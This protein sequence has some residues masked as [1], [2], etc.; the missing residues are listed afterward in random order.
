VAA[1]GLGAV[2]EPEDLR[3]LDWS[4]RVGAVLSMYAA[5]A[6]MWPSEAVRAG[7]ERAAEA[8]GG[9]GEGAAMAAALAPAERV[10]LG[11]ALACVA[12]DS[13]AM[14]GHLLAR[15]EGAI[16]AYKLGLLPLAPKKLK[17]KIQATAPAPAPAVPGA[18][19]SAA[20]DI[21]TTLDVMVGPSQA[22]AG[23][24]AK[25]GS[26][27]VNV[28]AA[29]AAAGVTGTEAIEGGESLAAAAETTASGTGF[30][31]P[32][33]PTTP[34]PIAPALALALPSSRPDWAESLIEWVAKA[35]D[36]SVYL[37]SRAI[38]T[39][40]TGRKYHCLGGSAGAALVFV[41][42]PAE[43]AAREA[44][45][46][47]A[48]KGS[49]VRKDLGASAGARDAQLTAGLRVKRDPAAAVAG[50]SGLASTGAGAEARAGAG[51]GRGGDAMDVDGEGGGGREAEMQLAAAAAA[52]AFKA[53]AAEARAARRIADRSRTAI[54]RGRA[55]S[56]A[57]AASHEFGEWPT[58]WSCFAVG[59][60]LRSLKEWLDDDP[61]NPAALEERRLKSLSSLLMRTAPKVVAEGAGVKEEEDKKEERAGGGD[62]EMGMETTG[63]VAVAVLGMGMTGVTGVE[64]EGRKVDGFEQLGLVV[65][66]YAN[67]DAADPKP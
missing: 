23:G 36:R 40:E 52:D 1:K 45:D 29:D 58:T 28:E 63:T 57:I 34:I 43:D 51:D 3:L 15:L 35:S 61:R 59:D 66:G 14:R 49:R 8:L 33:A 44:E 24:G 21:Q 39:D 42:E 5:G 19:S 67:L 60:G 32:S 65:D 53:S 11:A 16:S 55:R 18:P 27:D 25:V 20:R 4:E 31:P 56:A 22:A 26:K 62:V 47:Q 6:A 12:V 46:A 2:E 37:R 50:L 64:E 41:E 17:P 48:A 10:A 13:E 7:A 54:R 30:I 38:A 9:C